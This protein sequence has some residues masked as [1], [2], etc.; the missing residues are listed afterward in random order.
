MVRLNVNSLEQKRMEKIIE[1]DK[2][3]LNSHKSLHLKVDRDMD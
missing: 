3:Q 1:E 2:N